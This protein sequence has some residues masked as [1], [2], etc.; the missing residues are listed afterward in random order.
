MKN[1]DKEILKLLQEGKSYSDIQVT[2][3]VSPSQIVVVKK[4][5]LNAI[6][7][8]TSTPITAPTT[9]TQEKKQEQ[10]SST[11]SALHSTTTTTKITDEALEK[12][13][14]ELEVELKNFDVEKSVKKSWKAIRKNH[15]SIY[16]M[17]VEKEMNLGDT[18][19]YLTKTRKNIWR[20]P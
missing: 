20:R 11:I 8:P 16:E 2:L 7:A 14:L 12:E 15:P 13:A 6:V 4:K 5:F 1:K 18:L 17:A 10:P 19:A 9:T 3:S